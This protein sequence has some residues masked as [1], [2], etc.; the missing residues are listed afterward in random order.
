MSYLH[1]LWVTTSLCVFFFHF[2]IPDILLLFNKLAAKNVDQLIRK[3][4]INI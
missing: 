2:E 1:S 3:I 4:N